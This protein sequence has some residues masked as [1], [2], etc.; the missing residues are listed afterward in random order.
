MLSIRPKLRLTKEVCNRHC[1][2]GVTG[3][4]TQPSCLASMTVY[5]FSFLSLVKHIKINKKEDFKSRADMNRVKKTH[6]NRLI[7]DSFNE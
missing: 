7:F 4:L 5:F 6:A 2:T 3:T 1:V